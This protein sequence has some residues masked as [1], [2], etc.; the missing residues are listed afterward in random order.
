MNY[1]QNHKIAQVGKT[2]LVV[3]V[4]IGSEENYARA[5]DWRGIELTRKVFK[6][7][8]TQDGYTAFEQWINENKANHVKMDVFVGCEPTGHYWYTFGQ[9]VNEQKMKLVFVNPY[10]V[11]RSKELD[12]NSPKKTDF[13]DPKT[14]AKLVVEGRYLYPY[15][16][17]G[18]YADLREAV[19]TRDRIVKE[20]NVI[21][22]RIQRWLKIYFPEYLKV[23][24]TFDS[25]SG[26]AVLEQAPL[27]ED[28]IRLGA[29]K[30]IGIWRAKKMRNVGI[31]RAMTLV[32]AAHNSI[33][34]PGGMCAK[35]ELRLLLEDYW[36]KQN[37]LAQITQVLETETLKIPNV[38]KLLAI[39]G[40]GIITV[41]GFLSEVGDLSRFN[42]PKQIQK[43]AG[44]ELKENSS[45]KCK[46]RSSI[47]K[48][49]R[50][51]LRKIL[52]Q[53]VL[54]MIRSNAEFKEVY[55]YYTTRIRNPLK[56]KQ[57]IVA[58]SCKLIRVFYS[59]LKHGTDYNADKLRTDIVRPLELKAA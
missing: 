57:A 36:T 9:F 47:S 39:K 33:G 24:K 41:A 29:D 15:I 55:Q 5:F 12:D 51:K 46:G 1:T 18:L 59:L 3:G 28:V 35:M 43:L 37:Q 4:D 13:K 20:L 48:R 30:I 44:L 49:G 38:E 16:P 21:S 8:N 22:N 23:Y 31:K 53:V 58:L 19:A 52:F 10:H 27:P 25:I 2:T 42:S 17:K 32:E 34:M 45:G 40:V 50:K 56:G 6:F 7:S 54:P 26:L 11:K 14:I